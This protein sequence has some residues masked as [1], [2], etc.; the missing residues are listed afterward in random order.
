MYFTVNLAFINY[1]DNLT[2][3]FKFPI[4]L[5]RTTYEQILL[6]SLE[7]FDFEPEILKAPKTL[8]EFVHQFQCK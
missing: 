4:F 7:E 5:N 6:I 1:F 3:F 2:D 8:K